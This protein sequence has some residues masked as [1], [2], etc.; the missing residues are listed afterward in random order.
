M[1]WF[2]TVGAVNRL[3]PIFAEKLHAIYV[4]L[5]LHINSRKKHY[6]F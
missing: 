3:G 2:Y 4:I 1:K 6:L 5:H